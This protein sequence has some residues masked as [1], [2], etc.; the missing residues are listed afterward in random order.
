MAAFS[1]SIPDTMVKVSF[2]KF[3][4]KMRVKDIKKQC[5]NYCRSFFYGIDHLLQF[6]FKSS[7]HPYKRKT[8]YIMQAEGQQTFRNP[9]NL[10]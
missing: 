2:I 8:I 10:N 4:L 9:L 3:S 6:F 5:L 7:A 1:I